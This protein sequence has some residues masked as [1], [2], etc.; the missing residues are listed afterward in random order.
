MAVDVV[1][2]GPT[3]AMARMSARW[4][5]RPCWTPAFTKRRRSSIHISSSTIAAIASQSRAA[6]YRQKRW[7][8]WLAAL[9][10]LGF[11]AWSSS[12]EAL[13]QLLDR[14]RAGAEDGDER[15]RRG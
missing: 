4:A 5:S 10:S 6:K 7:S 13:A 9:S 11:G 14:V 12:T 1:F 15:E 3:S 8:S 2:L